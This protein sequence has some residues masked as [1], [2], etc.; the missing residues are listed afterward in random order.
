MIQPHGASPMQ[1]AITALVIPNDPNIDILLQANYP[2]SFSFGPTPT[3]WGTVA[4]GYTAMSA[5]L[6]QILGWLL[7]RAIA[8]GEW[9]S[10]SGAQ[11]V[12]RGLHVKAYA[13]P[14]ADSSYSTSVTPHGGPAGVPRDDEWNGLC[15]IE[16]VRHEQQIRA[17]LSGH[18]NRQILRALGCRRISTTGGWRASS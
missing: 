5:S 3:T 17:R 9:V 12:S 8:I 2:S 1:A 10:V 4:G 7:N 14:V 6:D 18:L 16:A 13:P 11:L 15:R